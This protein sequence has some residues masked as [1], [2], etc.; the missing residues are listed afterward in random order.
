[1]ARPPLIPIDA[2]NEKNI[3][4]PSHC[5]T[6]APPL[7]S[8]PAKFESSHNRADSR[9]WLRHREFTEMALMEEARRPEQSRVRKGEMRH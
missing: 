6:P 3:T 7:S 1:M 4:E 2:F 5:A 8:E 9:L